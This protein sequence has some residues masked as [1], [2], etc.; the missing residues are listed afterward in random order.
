VERERSHLG[1]QPRVEQ[2]GRAQSNEAYTGAGSRNENSTGQWIGQSQSANAGGSDCRC[3]SGGDISQTQ[4]GSNENHT[5]QDATSEARTEQRNVNVPISVLS[6]GGGHCGCAARGNDVDQSNRATTDAYS[7]NRNGTVQVIDQDQ[8]ATSTGGGGSCCQEPE[9]KPWSEHACTCEKPKD[10]SY[11]HSCGCEPKDGNGITQTQHAD[12]TNT[13]D[14]TA[15]SRATTDQT[16]W[17]SPVS[18]LTIGSTKGDVD[19]SNRATTNAYS[20]NEN[21]TGQWVDQQQ[22]AT[23]GGK[24]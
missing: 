1:P 7:G 3:G 17:N 24:A 5:T 11:E 23:E 16:N 14:Q 2:R 10:P 15:D 4:T 20:R 8:T 22:D 9:R 12:N 13:T 19:Q 21:R 6:I 18:F